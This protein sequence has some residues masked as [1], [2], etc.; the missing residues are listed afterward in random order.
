MDSE[1]EAIVS[2]NRSEPL[3]RAKPVNWP[4][5]AITAGL[6]ALSLF[7]YW[8][9]F[10]AEGVAL[11]DKVTAVLAVIGAY[12]IG[13]TFLRRSDAL[14]PVC[15]QM[16]EEVTS[17]NAA[18]CWAS[19]LTFLGMIASMLSIALSSRKTTRQ[20]AV[21]AILSS[22]TLIALALGVFVYVFFHAL[23]VVPITY[24][25]ILVASAVVNAYETAAGD[26][27]IKV[28]NDRGEPPQQMSLKALVLKDT[29]ASKTFI[30]GLPASIIAIV[31]KTVMPFLT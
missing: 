2:E 30:M 4:L 29:V 31:G 27:V 16:V 14:G 15:K 19:N 10:S 22:F 13:L 17:P 11:R 20:P 25:A 6:L 23:V 28:T 21:L 5:V 26:S 18:L 12:G 9:I 1:G 24:P 7:E 8:L 3:P